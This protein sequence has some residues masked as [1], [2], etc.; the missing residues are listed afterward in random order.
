MFVKEWGGGTEPVHLRDLEE[1]SKTLVFRR[2]ISGATFK[3]FASI[4]MV[5]AP[6]YI[7]SCVKACLVAPENFCRGNECRLFTTSDCAPTS[8]KHKASAITVATM[9]RHAAKFMETVGMSQTDRCKTMSDFQVKCV[10]HVHGKKSRNRRCFGNL[11]E[12]GQW[13]LET[14]W[15]LY[16]VAK[17]LD[18]PWPV[19]E[20]KGTSP[21][22]GDSGFRQ[23]SSTGGVSSDCLGSR[24]FK[25]GVTIE[26]ENKMYIIKNL[27]TDGGHFAGEGRRR[28]PRRRRRR[29]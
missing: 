4:P 1:F 25:T 19:L 21:K 2:D 22:Q 8:S 15:E 18:Q 20:P 7:V 17:D 16:P 24:G 5:Q 10:V 23:F 27:S 6:E 13:L 26:K 14:I 12:I 29:R 11:K 28:R 9:I 3:A